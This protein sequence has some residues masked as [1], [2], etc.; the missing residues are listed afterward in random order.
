MVIFGFLIILRIGWRLAT[1]EISIYLGI[2]IAGTAL[3]GFSFSFAICEE[4]SKEKRCNSNNWRKM[5][6]EKEERREYFVE[7]KK[8][9]ADTEGIGV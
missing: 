5:E 1:V 2:V 4:S 6:D 7:H 3:K 9:N 8:E